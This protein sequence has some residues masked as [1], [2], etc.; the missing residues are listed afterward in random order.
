MQT[1]MRADGGPEGSGQDPG[2]P[3]APRTDQSSSAGGPS[4]GFGWARAV[5]AGALTL[6]IIGVPTDI[7]ANPWFSREIPVRWWEYPVLAATCLLTA[8]WFGIRT[9]RPDDEG[10]RTGAY[11]G[12]ALALF[13]VGCPVCNKV[14]L[15]AIGTSGALG[16]W[17][18]IQPYLAVVSLVLLGAAVAYRW[19]RRDCG[20]ACAA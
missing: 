10:G 17:A 20:P 14:V 11:G 19:R 1:G 4:V 3:Q 2:A 9:V 12:A 13:A 5:V 7:I 18:P 6:V 8:A 16:V 15:L